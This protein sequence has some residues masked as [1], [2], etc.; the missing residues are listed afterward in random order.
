MGVANTPRPKKA[1]GAS[2]ATASTRTPS[3]LA[4]I[5]NRRRTVGSS[6]EIQYGLT[7]TSVE[8]R[9]RRTRLLQSDLIRVQTGHVLL[10]KVTK[11]HPPDCA[12]I[13]KRVARSPVPTS[14]NETSGSLSPCSGPAGGVGRAVYANTVHMTARLVDSEAITTREVRTCSPPSEV[15]P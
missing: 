10:T 8:S 7:C 1:S 5:T 15:N 14:S 13:P 12:A 3:R 11:M 6:A 9:Q 2:S 4:P